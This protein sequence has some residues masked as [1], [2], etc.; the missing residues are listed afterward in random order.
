MLSKAELKE[1]LP[2]FWEQ[3]RFDKLAVVPLAHECL[4][5]DYYSSA[6]LKE[7]IIEVTGNTDRARVWFTKRFSS[8]LLLFL[9]LAREEEKWLIPHTEWGPS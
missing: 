2:E 6:V 5:G 7:P 4:N 3:M 9:S 8:S 1:R